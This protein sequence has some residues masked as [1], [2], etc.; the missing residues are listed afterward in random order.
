MR[1]NPQSPVFLLPINELLALTNQG[2]ASRMA[3]EELLRAWV[4]TLVNTWPAATGAAVY[5]HDGAALQLHTAQDLP[6]DFDTPPPPDS[7]MGRAFATQAAVTPEEVPDSEHVS[8]LALPLMH[9]SVASGVLYVALAEETSLPEHVRETLASLTNMLGLAISQATE[10]SRPERE[11]QDI[12]PVLTALYQIARQLSIHTASADTFHAICRNLTLTP[13]VIYAAIV[14]MDSI[15]ANL[16]LVAEHPG[17][18]N[19]K[20]ANP[21]QGLALAD[22][23]RANPTPTLLR[24]DDNMA[25]VLGEHFAP[26]RALPLEALLV[27]PLRAQNEVV[28]VLLLASDSA[29]TTFTQTEVYIAEA[30][31]TQI[32]LS[33]RNTELFK[34]IQHRANQLE[35]TTA[36]GRLVTSTFEETEILQHVAEIVPKLLECHYVS[37][38]LYVEGQSQMRVFELQQHVAPNAVTVSAGG[39]S[40]E[41]IIRSQSPLLVPDVQRST[42]TDHKRIAQHNLSAMITVPLIASQQPLGT[43]SIANRKADVYTPTDLTLLQQ[44][45]TQVAIALENAYLFQSTQQRAA[46]E[47]ALSEITSRLQQQTDLRVLLEQTMRDLGVILGANQ[48]RVRLRLVPRSDGSQSKE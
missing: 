21:L 45:G 16:Y 14:G 43:L 18:I 5:L 30:I 17:K 38:V 20:P 34:S 39:S 33:L 6:D 48:A 26:I 27:A 47:E 29:D 9:G 36:F 10:P 25:Q 11:A 28:G 23:V 2:L 19:V 46:Y 41:E 7:I 35:Q 31:A 4:Q 24:A 22:Y 1:E 3:R 12:K 13:G 15:S 37:V 32:A 8:A 40:V 44:I 42:F